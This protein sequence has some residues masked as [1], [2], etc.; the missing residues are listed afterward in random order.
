MVSFKMFFY[1]PEF[2][3]ADLHTSVWKLLFMVGLSD[4]L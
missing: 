1:D 4:I 2:G 3:V